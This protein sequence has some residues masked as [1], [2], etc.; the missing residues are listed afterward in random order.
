MTENNP[1]PTTE[2][3]KSL[4]NGTGRA[5]VLIQKYWQ[6]DSD[7]M[8]PLLLHALHNDLR[9]DNLD[10]CRALYLYTLFGLTGERESF[11]QET[12]KALSV[13][14]SAEDDNC[15]QLMELALI[16]AQNGDAK[17]HH[18][19]YTTFEKCATQKDQPDYGDIIVRV[20][21]VD[22][23]LWLFT[24]YSQPKFGENGYDTKDFDHFI[25]H[26][27]EDKESKTLAWELLEEKCQ[28]NTDY[29]A[30]FARQKTYRDEEET[31]K[32]EEKSG[33]KEWYKI[34]Y[35]ELKA[36]IEAK[37]FPYCERWGRE[38]AP[39]ELEKAAHDLLAETDPKILFYKL[40]IFTQVPFPLPIAPLLAWAQ[41]DNHK[42]SSRAFRV[43]GRV[44][45][46]EVRKI[47]LE[48]LASNVE[49]NIAG[50]IKMLATNY[51]A[52]DE[53]LIVESL[54]KPCLSLFRRHH[55]H[56]KARDFAE[57]HPSDLST[58]IF[59]L[60][61]AETNCVFCRS[62]VVKHLDSLGTL[63]EAIQEELAFDASEDTRKLATSSPSETNVQSS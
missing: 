56:M 61:Y 19:I 1:F 20:D 29:L 41:S 44:K 49:Q 24:N 17:A 54:K 8:R 30:F 34:S 37:Q 32:K 4:E 12:L 3:T 18:A 40:P 46:E 2:F 52:G 27:L 47:A 36:L 22:G 15:Y 39:E 48:L 51:E 33:R 5:G 55:Q 7:T 28:G 14:E 31:R 13:I 57:E 42:V 11:R 9:S 62:I 38:A 25:R 53:H 60:I 6:T 50:A 63:T 21:G 43:L 23:L 35:D 59:L 26:P 58:E 45:S 10:D 16:F